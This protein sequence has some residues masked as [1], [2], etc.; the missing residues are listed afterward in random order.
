MTEIK[1]M[2]NI[3]CLLL[4]LIAFTAKSQKVSYEKLDAISNE[5][6]KLQFEANGLSYEEGGV[7]HEISF[8]E[9][10][11]KVFYYNKLA[12]NAIYVKTNGTEVLELTE[13]IDLSNATGMY[14]TLINTQMLSLKLYFP[15]GY[16]KTQIIE[17]GKTVKTVSKEYLEFFRANIDVKN[18]NLAGD[19]YELWGSLRVDK[20]LLTQKQFDKEKADWNPASSTGMETFIKNYPKSL[21]VK[22][23]K[24]AIKRYQEDK[25]AAAE[26]IRNCKII[27]ETLSWRPHIK[28]P[29]FLMTMSKYRWDRKPYSDRSEVVRHTESSDDGGY[30]AEGP[31]GYKIN[32]AG[33]IYEYTNFT[34]K[35]K[36]DAETTRKLFEDA[37]AIASKGK[38]YRKLDEDS[39]R[40]GVPKSAEQ[41]D[42]MEYYITFA[43]RQMGEWSTLDTKFH[44]KK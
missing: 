31:A 18:G 37:R 40:I 19:F 41:P 7:N 23:A 30:I 12:T 38:Y 22:E 1:I 42:E 9:D 35:A 36:N 15:P 20:G 4:L 33:E 6:S 34:R 14:F 24:A 27:C 10:N 11:F 3:L 17:N 26:T 16:L 5:I 32:L 13:N 28:E 43:Y 8:P 44:I 2:K 29:E 21:R 25:I 39:Y